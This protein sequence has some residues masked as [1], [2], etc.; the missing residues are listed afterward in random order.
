MLDDAINSNQY[1]KPITT[2]FKYITQQYLSTKL[3]GEKEIEMGEVELKTDKGLIVKDI[4]TERAI[5]KYNKL[6]MILFRRNKV[7]ELKQYNYWWHNERIP[8]DSY[9]ALD[10]KPSNTK[11]EILRSYMKLIDVFALVG[12]VMQTML[13]FVSV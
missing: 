5:K 3:R 2:L 11:I 12:G 8:Y 9:L 10:I 1:D 13:F 4:K 6:D 7:D